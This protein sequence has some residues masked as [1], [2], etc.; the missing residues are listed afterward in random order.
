MKVEINKT[1]IHDNYTEFP[2]EGDMKE[3]K[4]N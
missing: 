4:F 3:V 2:L 1:Y